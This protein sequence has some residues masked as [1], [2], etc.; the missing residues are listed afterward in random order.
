MD[1]MQRQGQYP[2]P[3]GS[4]TILGVEFAGTISAVGPGVTKWQVGD[5]VMGLAG[6]GAYAEY[7][8]SLDTHVVPK[9]SRLSWTEAASIPEAFLTG[10]P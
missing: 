1:I 6:G 9:P 2:P 4:S 3:A 5:E 7:I 10:M 8:V